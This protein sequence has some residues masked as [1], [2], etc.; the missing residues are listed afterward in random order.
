MAI[1]FKINEHVSIFDYIRFPDNIIP[2]KLYRELKIENF[3][4]S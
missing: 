3:A 2:H 1:R 4:K